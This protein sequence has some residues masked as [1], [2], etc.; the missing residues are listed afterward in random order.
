MQDSNSEK[1][2]KL[3]RRDSSDDYHDTEDQH[4]PANSTAQGEVAEPNMPQENQKIINHPLKV[5]TPGNAVAYDKANIEGSG[6]KSDT[7]RVPQN[8]DNDETMQESKSFILEKSQVSIMGDARQLGKKGNF[9]VIRCGTFGKSKV[10][11]A[12]KMFKKNPA[13][14]PRNEL[15]IAMK[16]W[17]DG[18]HNCI[19][20]FYGVWENQAAPQDYLPSC[21]VMELCLENTL[22]DH[23]EAR[24]KT[25]LQSIKKALPFSFKEKV[26]SFPFKEKIDL[27]L[28]VAKGMAF[29]HSRDIV[30]GNL[31]AGKILLTEK[32]GVFRAKV[33]GFSLS[34]DTRDGNQ[35]IASSRLNRDIM[36]PEILADI[37]STNRCQLTQAVD[38]FSYGCLMIHVA[39]CKFPNPKQGTS[40][41]ASRK[42][43]FDDIKVDNKECFTQT[44][45]KLLSQNPEE[46]GSFPSLL[47]HLNKLI[48]PP[49]LNEVSI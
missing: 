5:E 10:S 11:C 30:H 42:Y 3:K 39:T 41:L 32:E 21:L 31:H 12:I 36:P 37:K 44:I 13:H 6:A 48:P 18:G 22:N 45:E 29:I 1:T 28:N 34:T 16:L 8:Q 49:K 40:A 17:K 38:V 14:E 46:R 4:S 33:A 24:K 27:L 26:L 25:T 7:V 47:L 35:S 23:L 9:A 43:L 20:T 2:S 15:D 19:V